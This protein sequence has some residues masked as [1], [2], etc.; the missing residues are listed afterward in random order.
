LIGIEGAIAAVAAR[1]AAGDLTGD[2]GDV[3]PVD[4]FGAA[5]TLEQALPCRLHAASERR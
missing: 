1:D 2:I 4:S 3:E 5:L